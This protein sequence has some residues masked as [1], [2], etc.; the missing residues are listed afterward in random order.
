MY[1][2]DKLEIHD[3]LQNGF[4]LGHRPCPTQW[5]IYNILVGEWMPLR[6]GMPIFEVRNQA[7]LQVLIMHAVLYQYTC[8]TELWSLT[9]IQSLFR[10]QQCIKQTT[11]YWTLF[12]LVTLLYYMTYTVILSCRNLTFLKPYSPQHWMTQFVKCASINHSK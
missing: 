9:P 5:R 6:G 12:Q 11:V 8:L 7:L 3:F 4:T 1:Y 2:F 10:T